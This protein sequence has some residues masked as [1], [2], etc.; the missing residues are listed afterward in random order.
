MQKLIIAGYCGSLLSRV[1]GLKHPFHNPS[2]IPVQ[3]ARGLLTRL[4]ALFRN[5][6]SAISGP[7]SSRTV[8]TRG[9]KAATYEQRGITNREGLNKAR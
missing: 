2:D 9:M 8:A 7:L 1:A 6:Q 5:D 3:S 4:I